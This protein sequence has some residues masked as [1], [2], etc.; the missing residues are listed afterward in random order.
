MLNFIINPVA[1]KGKTLKIIDKLK[2]YCVD[3][4]I[5]HEFFMTNA[6]G[7][8]T[9]IAKHICEQKLG[10]IVIVGGDG[11]INEVLN[12]MSDFENVNLGLV[13]YGTGNDFAASLN[14][15]AKNLIKAMDIIH[16]NNPQYT[17]F[18]ELN[19]S[20][21]VMNVT[22]M[23]I[24]VDV[25]QRYKKA[26]IIKGKFAYY[27]ALIVSLFRFKWNKY[28]IKFENGEFEEKTA[29]I[30]AVCNGKFIGGGI[31]ICPAADSS[32]GLLNVVIVNKIP[33]IKILPALITLMKGK[34]LQKKFVN[35]VLCKNL[36]LVTDAKPVINIDGELIKSSNFECNIVSGKLKI[37]R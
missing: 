24:D 4:N 18:I 14:I 10:N 30:T 1:G 7:D 37:Y 32:D 22:G 35:H 3:K 23:G 17:D 21:R 2:D 27:K 9:V 20:I 5:K 16:N 19:N 15:E 12:G 13:P 8:A 26:K 36:E 33:R 34:I 31:K 11:T 25:L 28:K 29:M 6:I